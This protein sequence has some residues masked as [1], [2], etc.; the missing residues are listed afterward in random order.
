[1]IER[2]MNEL[3]D[4]SLDKFDRMTPAMGKFK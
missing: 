2:Y 4:Q 3:L 1:L